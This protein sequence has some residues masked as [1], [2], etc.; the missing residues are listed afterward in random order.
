VAFLVG[1]FPKPDVV[2]WSPPSCS[3]KTKKNAALPPLLQFGPLELV[4]ERNCK[5]KAS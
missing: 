2:Q 3:Q 1:K 4:T 5:Q